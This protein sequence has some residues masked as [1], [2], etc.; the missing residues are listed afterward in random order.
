LRTLLLKPKRSWKVQALAQSAGVSIGQASNVKRLLQEREW[1]G[2]ATGDGADLTEDSGSASGAGSG[3]GSGDGSGS[4]SGI[5]FVLT[6][7]AKLLE[8]WAQNYRFDRNRVRD[9]YSLDTPAQL[10]TKLAALCKG[11][12]T[13]YTLTG[14]SAAAR[15]SPMVRYQRATA[16]I[17]GKVDDIATELALKPVSSGANISLIDPYDLGVFAGSR[18][19]HGIRIASAIQTYLDLLSFK[20]RGEEAAQAVLEQAI[21]PRW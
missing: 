12:G 21:K 2:R 4:T 7:P 8:E 15:I 20:G 17:T 11:A 6:K 10:E 14:F 3:D 5:G 13:R 9:F 19:I 1:I 16:Y 18:E